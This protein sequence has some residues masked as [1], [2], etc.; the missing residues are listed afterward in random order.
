MR[1]RANYYLMR[2]LSVIDLIFE[3]F[4]KEI[5]YDRRL[6]IVHIAHVCAETTTTRRWNL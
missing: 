4:F 6:E 2:S 3:Y 1:K 5:E